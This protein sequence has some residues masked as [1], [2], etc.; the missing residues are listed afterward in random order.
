MRTRIQFN[1]FG[2]L[3]ASNGAYAGLDFNLTEGVTPL[4]HDIY[5]LHMTI[6]WI[7]VAIGAVVFG[8]MLYS[9]IH[10]RKS[11]GA[12]AVQFHEKT[13]VEIIW[14]LIPLIILILMAIPATRV[15]THMN[16]MEKE[17]VTIKITGYQWKWRYEYID[18]GISFFS[19]NATPL[20]QLNGSAPKDAAYL[21]TVDHP[22]VVPIHKKIRFLITSNDVIHSWWVP[23]FGV[24]R[25]ALPGFINEAWARINRPGI[26][27]GQC[28]ELCGVNHAYMIIVVI[29][30]TEEGFQNW[31]AEEKGLKPPTPLPDMNQPSTMPKTT[32][33]VDPNK[34]FTLEELKQQGEQVYMSICAA[35]HQPTG[36]G[37]PP[38]FPS[39]KGSAIVNG[40]VAGHMN[41]VLNGK[42]GTAMQAF[43]D[44]L[45]DQELAAVIT[46]ERNS[47]GNNTGTLVQPSDIKAARAKPPTD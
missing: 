19:N 17:D 23:A 47:F 15:L 25:D 45:N 12:K 13:S 29:A 20:A 35:C 24:K 7:C 18:Q 43:K 5:S 39:L 46:Y 38:T 26:Y 22:L 9:I 44:Q 2:L 31:I 28:T 3:L 32:T 34:K 4:S 21:R 6:F 14:T 41:R 37:M 42:A 8:V 10:H 40:P 16:D 11:K 36:L 30:T 33:P 1:L 27:Y